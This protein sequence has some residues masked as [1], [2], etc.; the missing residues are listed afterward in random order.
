VWVAHLNQLQF[1]FPL[2]PHHISL[3]MSGWSSEGMD[4][5]SHK[6]TA[7]TFLRTAD[8]SKLS[9]L[10]EIGQSELPVYAEVTRTLVLGLD[11]YVTT[12]V[13][14]VSGTAYPVILNIPLL[15]GESVITDNIK[16]KNE[17]VVITLN[18]N[19]RSYSW[20]SKL[21]TSILIKLEASKQEKFIEKWNLDVSPVWNVAFKGIPVIY[22]Q[23]QGN[24]WRPEWQPWP[25]EKVIITVGRPKG[26]KGKT[27][28]IDSSTLT[29][30][31]GE[32]ITAAKLVFNLR[33]SL[34]GQHVIRLPLDADLQTVKINNQN[35][36]IRNTKEGLSL[37]VSPGKQKVEID[38]REAQ[39]ISTIFH[40]SNIDLGNSSVN[41]AINLK[42]GYNRWVL[43]ASGPTMG[44][45][46]LF[47][48]MLIVIII[49]AYALGQVKDT[50]LN[51]L[52][53]VLLG[54]GLSASGPWGLVVIAGCIFALRARGN[55]KTDGMRWQLFNLMQVGLVILI[56][57]SVSTL[58]SVI[59]QG[60]L[61]SPD[62]QITGNGSSS[63]Q[64]NWFSDRTAA[65]IPEATLISVPVYVYRLMMLAWSI[66]LAFA[67][68]NWAKWGWGN[69]TKQ[70]YWKS[71]PETKKPEDTD[72][73]NKLDN[74]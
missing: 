65:V 56:F 71:A 58:F 43:F 68:I 20:T 27:L 59:E 23:R 69:Y 28:T 49:I 52:Q 1:S 29:L 39:G 6:I 73:K 42:P 41:N 24:N 70:G 74:K 62:M 22:H 32:Q 50:P 33:S 7:L 60:L 61:G 12:H 47:W 17:H 54:F 9:S 21:D 3:K 5:E 11:W 53:W 14:G 18:N 37:P 4:Q 2:K 44:P 66:W 51:S 48:G 55:L 45:A 25:G 64:L 63:Y 10:I 30:T 38:W 13:R 57:I 16:V 34:G 72:D 40:S 15:N 36:P 67:L 8:K 26:V 19:R 31:P 46:V 35:M